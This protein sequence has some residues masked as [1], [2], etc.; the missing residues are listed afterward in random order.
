MKDKRVILT[1]VWLIL[2]VTLFVCGILEIVDSYWSGMGAGLL[3]VGI[4]QLVRHIRY[5][6]NTEYREAVEIRNQDERNK[7]LSGKA[8][9]WAGYLYVLINGIAVIGLKLAGFEELS[10][11]A[12]WNVCIVILL[13]WVCWM[14]LH[15]KY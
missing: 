15:K 3:A 1:F 14:V 7:F 10:V 6:T 8:W 12:A 13:Y 2:G 5:R 11:W 4:L 9:A